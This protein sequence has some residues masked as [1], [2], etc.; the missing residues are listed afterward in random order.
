MK[1]SDFRSLLLSCELRQIDAAWLCGVHVRQVKAWCSGEY[2]VPHYAAVIVS[3]YA[4]GLLPD[5]WVVSR[6]GSPP[7]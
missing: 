3:A 7:P 2:P 5:R 4:E 1:S 6:L